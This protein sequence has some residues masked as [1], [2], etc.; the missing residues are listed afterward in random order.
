[1]TASYTKETG[2][3][4]SNLKRNLSDRET[5]WRQAHPPTDDDEHS[6]EVVPDDSEYDIQ[7]RA[8]IAVVDEES[9]QRAARKARA[10]EAERESEQ[11]ARDRQALLSAWTDKQRLS[12]P[13]RQRKK[14]PAKHARA[15][16]SLAPESEESE[17]ENEDEEDES[18]IESVG[19]SSIG[20]PIAQT[21]STPSP[22]LS[23][24]SSVSSRGRRGSR[25]RAA[26][27]QLQKGSKKSKDSF[28]TSVEMLV[29]SMLN[30][31]KSREEQ[32]D[33][34]KGLE[35]RM[36][37][38]EAGQRAI[39]AAVTGRS[40]YLEQRSATIEKEGEDLHVNN[41]NS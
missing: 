21:S 27:R 34:Q 39:L 10:G 9:A 29:M 18:A 26:S 22:E 33:R 6:G 37:A 20:T 35:A 17:A 4:H 1:V 38:L 19:E 15:V 14:T 2:R 23:R 3:T 40:T 41:M 5:A 32:E 31:Q 25:K 24:S 36:E 11:S 8:W 12:A 13:Y 30:R 7:M 16:S 28:E